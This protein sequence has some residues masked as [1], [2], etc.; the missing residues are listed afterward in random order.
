LSSKTVHYGLVM[1]LLGILLLFLAKRVFG[2]FSVALLVSF[3]LM[4]VGLLIIRRGV[5]R[6]GHS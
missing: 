2:I 4:I 3:V 5:Q 6:K 1:I